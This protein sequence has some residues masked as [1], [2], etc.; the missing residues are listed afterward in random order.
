MWLVI[1]TLLVVGASVLM[2]YLCLLGISRAM[3]R[4]RIPNPLKIL[5]GVVAAIGAHVLQV[6]MF[7]SVYH[8]LA[9]G[10]PYGGA[11]TGAYD[12]SFADSLYFSFATYT[13]LGYG[14]IEPVGEL[15]YLT[16]MEALTGFVMITWTASFLFLEMRR[17]W[18]R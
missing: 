16:G 2:H 1:L 7:A 13:T 12:G 14:D 5:V 17:Y 9:Q 4:M 11:L 10:S 18:D 15:R 3:P 8:E 6:A